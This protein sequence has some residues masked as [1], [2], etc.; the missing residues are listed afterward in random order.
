MHK[1]RRPKSILSFLTANDPLS[2]DAADAILEATKK[3]RKNA[4]Q[5]KSAEFE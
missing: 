2:E 3:G 1:Q 4:I 5:R